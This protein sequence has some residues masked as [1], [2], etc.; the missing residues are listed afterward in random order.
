MFLGPPIYAILANCCYTF[1]W[2]VDTTAYRGS[3]R[4][5]LLKAGLI[6]SV[7]L[8]ALPGIWAVTA[9]LTS[10]YTGRRLD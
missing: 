1:G 7:V 8:T 4:R 3:P 10:I 9:W 6:F 5:W 2:I